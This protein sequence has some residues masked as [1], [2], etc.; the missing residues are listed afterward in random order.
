MPEYGRWTNSSFDG[1]ERCKAALVHIHQPQTSWF[2]SAAATMPVDRF[3]LA[4]DLTH[5]PQC[6]LY[7]KVSEASAA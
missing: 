2:W 4:T 1:D 5:V 3:N 7:F 6:F